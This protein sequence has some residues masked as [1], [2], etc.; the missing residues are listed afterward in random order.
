MS[1]KHFLLLAIALKAL[2]N[3]SAPSGHHHKKKPGLFTRMMDK[4]ENM[5]T[6]TSQSSGYYPNYGYPQYRY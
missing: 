6:G 4:V 2:Q 3:Q 1:W 5:F